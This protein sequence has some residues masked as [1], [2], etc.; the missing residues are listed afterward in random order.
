DQASNYLLP[1]SGHTFHDWAAK[2]VDVVAKD[3][4]RPYTMMLASTTAGDFLPVQAIW[5]GK[6]PGSLPKM[7]AEKMEEA[8]RCSFVFSSTKRKKKTSY[9]ANFPT[10]EEWDRKVLVPW[11]NKV[12]QARPDLDEDQLMIA[13]LDIYPVHTGEEF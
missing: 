5:S 9:F 12:L 11:R 7:S 10:M 1:A 13:F 3:E 4:K 2:Q 8:V 6:T